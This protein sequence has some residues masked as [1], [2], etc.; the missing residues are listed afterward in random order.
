MVWDAFYNFIISMKTY[1]INDEWSENF[2]YKEPAVFLVSKTRI[3]TVF[4][5]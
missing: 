5:E 3:T 1:M 2:F 4:D